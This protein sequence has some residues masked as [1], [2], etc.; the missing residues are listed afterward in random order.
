MGM[1]APRAS[2]RT[3]TP[4]WRCVLL[5]A[6]SAT[7]DC[8]QTEPFADDDT[9]GG[10]RSLSTG[11]ESHV[12][13]MQRAGLQHFHGMN[14]DW[15]ILEFML[16]LI[17]LYEVLCCPPR[18]REKNLVGFTGTCKKSGPS[19]VEKWLSCHRSLFNSCCCKQVMG[20]NQSKGKGLLQGINTQRED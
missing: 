17:F 11:K 2:Q 18:G 5:L 14:F 3:R 13:E 8:P 6:A 1:G 15:D 12:E 20:Q 19:V 7:R 16:Y 10:P 4:R 9:R